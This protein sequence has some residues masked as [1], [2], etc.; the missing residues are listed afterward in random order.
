[1]LVQFM[2]K[3][4]L[5][6]KEET[7][8]DFTAIS[9]YK[10]HGY[11]LIDMGYKDKFLKVST[12]YGANASGKSNL[13]LAMN[14]FQTI[15]FE[16]FNN[17]D[18][19]NESI[20]SKR[21]TP[22]AFDG[23]HNNTEFELI[24]ILGDYQY[25][26]GFEYNETEIVSEW[27]YRKNLNT[28][29]NTTIFE[30]TTHEIRLGPTVKKHCDAFKEQIPTETL[31]LSFFNRLKL[32]TAVFNDVYEGI[33]G[34]LVAAGCLYEDDFFIEEYLP[35]IID[36]NKEDLLAFLSAIDVGIQD[37]FYEE[38][39]KEIDIY[40]IHSDINGTK[41]PLD[42]SYE[43]E[44]TL[45][46]LAIYICARM[47]IASDRSI[48]VDELNA[49]LHPLLLKFIVD[50]FHGQTDS[51]AQLIYTTHDTTLLDKRFLRRD[52]IWFVQKDSYGHSELS[53]L[54]DFKVR[55]DASFEKDYLA[56]VYGGIP[57]IK[58]FTLKVGEELG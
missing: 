49:R 24:Q 52:Q 29:R 43:S 15:V 57:S 1:M 51:R 33:R 34:T 30:R 44:G 31:A 36:Q 19:K 21:Y 47:A 14:A 6:F 35:T 42:I 9:A 27:L 55:T 17:S 13:F 20:I 56:G 23:E 4:F 45:K 5:S 3:N 10:E 40:T 18:A 39:D 41:Y 8:L 54:S 32:G 11:N 46:C 26:Y 7:R 28:N 53:A 58:D 48:F 25:K 16:S 50:L 38:K 12:I 22:F 37:I 2:L